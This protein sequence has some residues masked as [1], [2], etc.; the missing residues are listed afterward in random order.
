[1]V[2]ILLL[3]IIYLA[4][5]SLGLPDALL[6]VAWPAMQG[7]WNLPLDALGL[8]AIL[9]TGSTILS[10]LFSGIL[11]RKFGTGKITLFSCLTTGIALLG[12]SQIPSFGWLLLLAIPLGFGGG[13]VDAALNNYV[14]LHFEAH[15]MNWL[16]SF[17]GVGATLGPL[18]M[19]NVLQQT[20]SWRDGYSQIGTLQLGLS[21]LLLISLPLWRRHQK[22][23]AQ[24]VTIGTNTPSSKTIRS[25]PGLSFAL[26]TFLLYCAVEVSV[27]LWGSSYLTQIRGFSIHQA[28]GW[29]S[30][31]YGGITLGRFV[32]GF[33][34]FRLSNSQM[35]RSGVLIALSGT[36]LLAF[37][38]P[39]FLLA[40]A[41]V[42]IGL[43][44]SPIF[45]AMLHE[46]PKRFG[47]QRSQ[48]II[49]YQMAAGYLGSA[50]LPPALGIVV[51]ATSLSILP[52]FLTTCLVAIFLITEALQARTIQLEVQS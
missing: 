14:A 43:G 6:G 44:L 29:V 31:Y 3:F 16:H 47:T 21:L 40:G 10:S 27:G 11:I 39:N 15:H 48:S 34:S 30:A 13:S 45:P 5:I 1:M 51:K 38:I 7:D 9:L 25:T 37:P 33:A 36:I 19:A 35:I 8:A 28:A 2:T 12:I 17:W 49:G 50:I 22:E 52:Y 41:M 26:L 46:T 32:S 4:F 24:P 42:L 18:V 23:Q 20:G